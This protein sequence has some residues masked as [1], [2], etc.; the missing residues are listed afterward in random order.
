MA[1]DVGRGRELGVAEGR[2]LE[3]LAVDA[4]DERAQVVEHYALPVEERLLHL[5]ADGSEHGHGVGLGDGGTLGDVL[6][7]VVEVVGA[8]VA[9]LT[10][11]IVLR[12]GTLGVLTL[13]YFVGNRHNRQFLVWE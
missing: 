10:A 2:L 11:Q 8:G 7:E 12:V 3:T 13:G 4:D 5:G 9:G 1:P 6:G